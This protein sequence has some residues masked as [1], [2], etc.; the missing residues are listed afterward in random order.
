MFSAIDQTVESIGD[1][2]KR[3]LVIKSTVPPSTAKTKVIPYINEKHH[4]KKSQIAVANNPEFL[5]E[6]HC[7]DD[8]VNADRI[9]IGSE[10]D[11]AKEAINK[12]YSNSGIAIDNVSLN[13]AEFIKYLSNTTLACMISYA[14][15]MS[16]AADAIGDI[17]VADAFRILHTDKRWQTGS[18]RSYMYPG[19]GYGGYCL[20]KD[21]NAFYSLLHEMG[22]DCKMLE[23]AIK[24][25]D[26]MAKNTADKIAAKCQNKNDV[27]GILGLSFN[28]G[29]DDVRDTPAA[30]IIRELNAEG[31]SNI[32]A[33]DPVAIQNFKEMYPEISVKTVSSYAELIDAAETIAIVTAWE[34]F[35]NIK[36]L[37]DKPIIDCRYML[38]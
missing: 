17:D 2:K 29:S 28:V 1:N 10:D 3:V 38:K 23:Q 14:N 24:L 35:S 20:P 34:E 12:L 25:N 27:I 15:E 8:F 37:T 21:T 31:Y 36:S 7:W 26:N 13:T 18:I 6:G 33:Y 32:I 4:D 5:R 22:Y 19:C 16:L 30:K 9:V 11:F